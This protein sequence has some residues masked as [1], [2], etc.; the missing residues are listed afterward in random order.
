ME[1]NLFQI[2]DYHHQAKYVVASTF[3]IIGLEIRDFKD[4]EIN[5]IEKK[6][7]EFLLINRNFEKIMKKLNFGIVT[8]IK[9]L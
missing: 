8:N 5:P 1:A 9:R 4:L 2:R 7:I 3:R 6:S